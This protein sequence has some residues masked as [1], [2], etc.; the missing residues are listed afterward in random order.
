[1]KELILA[2]EKDA[3]DRSKSEAE[4]RGCGPVT[5]HWY[6]T[7]GAKLVIPEKEI[8]SLTDLEKLLLQ[9]RIL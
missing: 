6:E 8:D 9:D 7:D 3:Q 5:T 4:K 2:S 1:M